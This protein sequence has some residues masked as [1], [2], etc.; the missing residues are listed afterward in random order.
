VLQKLS[1]KDGLKD[2]ALKTELERKNFTRAA[3]LGLSHKLADSE[4]KYIQQQS[5]GQM[6]VIYRNAKGAKALARKFGYSK[7]DVREILGQYT[8][9]MIEKGNMKPLKARYDY[10][11]GKYL[12]FEQWFN[13]LIEKWRN[14]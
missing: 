14:E 8:D 10:A 2:E 11:S 5:L 3:H 13:Q 4:L 12:T 6:A 1:E 7:T 9:Q